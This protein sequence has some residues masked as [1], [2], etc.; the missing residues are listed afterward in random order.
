[1][2]EIVVGHSRKL[3]A[4]RKDG[5]DRCGF[6]LGADEHP[7]AWETR[8]TTGKRRPPTCDGSRPVHLNPVS[9]FLIWIN[10]RQGDVQEAALTAPISGSRGC[11]SR[12]TPAGEMLT[13]YRSSR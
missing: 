11:R 4:L 1:L 12:H 2:T 9:F 10:A 5:M 13:G 3:A 7:G 8:T 6:Y